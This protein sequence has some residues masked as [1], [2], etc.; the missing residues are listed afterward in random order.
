MKNKN[1]TTVTLVLTVIVLLTSLAFEF[2]SQQPFSITIWIMLGIFIGWL[3]TLL[4]NIRPTGSTK[5]QQVWLKYDGGRFAKAN[6]KINPWK[7]KYCWWDEENEQ[8]LI[9]LLEDGTVRTDELTQHVTNWRYVETG[10][11]Q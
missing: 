1:A 4:I 6:L 5:P 10:D 3:P 2:V 9:Q 7:E 8:G 11:S